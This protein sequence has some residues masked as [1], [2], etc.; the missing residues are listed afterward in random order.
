M[1]NGDRQKMENVKYQDPLDK[2]KKLSY[3]GHVMRNE[4]D[5]PEKEIMQGT[6]SKKAGETKD[7]MAWQH[8]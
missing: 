5:C 3:I 6:G 4:E 1:K 7:M 2:K 8:E